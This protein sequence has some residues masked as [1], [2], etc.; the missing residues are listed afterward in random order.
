LRLF[1][2]GLRRLWA[3]FENTAETFWHRNSFIIALFKSNVNTQNA[4]KC[5]TNIVD[6]FSKKLLTFTKKYGMM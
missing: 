1:L 2:G 6:V 4:Q 3:A 5:C